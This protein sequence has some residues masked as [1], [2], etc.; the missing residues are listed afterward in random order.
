MKLFYLI[1]A[2]VVFLLILTLG[3]PQVGTTCAFYLISPSSNPA[4]VIFQAAGLG[5]TLGGL[6][7]LYWKFPRDEQDEEGE[8]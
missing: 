6:L 1:G 5:A 2:V 4:L 8:A 3:L 7:V